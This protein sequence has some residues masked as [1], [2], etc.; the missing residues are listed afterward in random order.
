MVATETHGVD[1][2]LEAIYELEEEGRE[3]VQARLARRLGVTR[4][5]VSEQVG[6]LAK[7][8]M[9]E[10]RSR[11][12]SLTPHGHAVAEEAVR[13][14]R[15]AERFLTDVLKMPWHLAHQE[16]NRFQG[17]LT[18]AI[19][20]RM[21]EALAGAV[22]CPHGNPIPG[23]GATLDTTL[24]PLRDFGAGETVE[25]VRLLEDVELDTGAMRYFE[26]HGL[27]PG[28][29]IRVVEVAPDGTM[30][31]RVGSIESTL[32]P[33]LTDNLWVRPGGV[34]RKRAVGAGRVKRVAA[35]RVS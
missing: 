15:L 12:I 8:K 28:A 34:G 23:T 32:G 1:D 16:A 24:Q 4:A 3:V 18:E 7:M 25:L 20:E 6:R 11:V 30:S 22:T 29:R 35:G 19:E 5:S 27:V 9:I 31:L 14:H 21:M 26:E 17:G 10:V 13:R 33:K 2:Y